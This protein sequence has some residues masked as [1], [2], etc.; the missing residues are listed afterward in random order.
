MADTAQ[1]GDPNASEP[2]TLDL[3]AADD[4]GKTAGGGAFKDA[5]GLWHLLI[6]PFSIAPLTINGSNNPNAHTLY[7]AA[8]SW[9]ALIIAALA[10]A[11]VLHFTKGRA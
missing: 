8:D 7:S 1:P 5:A 9:R 3:S 6:A 11:A 4:A 10:V 2:T